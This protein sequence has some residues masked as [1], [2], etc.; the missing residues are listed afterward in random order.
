LAL[1]SRNGF[2]Y[3]WEWG[4]NLWFNC[5]RVR[6]FGVLGLKHMSNMYS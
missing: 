1:T 6:V 4:Q 5:T 2:A 3:I